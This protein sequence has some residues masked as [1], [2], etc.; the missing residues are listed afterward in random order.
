M[1]FFIKQFLSVTL[2]VYKLNYRKVRGIRSGT[3]KQSF[4]NFYFLKNKNFR[5]TVGGYVDKQL[6]A[7]KTNRR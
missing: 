1:L 7:L 5:S 6:R 2:F 4:F 3:T